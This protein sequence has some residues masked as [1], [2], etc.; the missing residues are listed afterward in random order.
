MLDEGAEAIVDAAMTT[1]H[2]AA[3]ALGARI[4][5]DDLV[6]KWMH[7]R[8][9]TSGLQALTR[10]GYVV[11]TM[12]V[13]ANWAGL[14]AVVEQV[15]SAMLSVPHARTAT[16]HLSHSYI[17]GACVYFTFA[18]N[19]PAEE[20]EATYLAMWERGQNAA[21][22]AGASLSHHHGVGLSRAGFMRA[23]LGNGLD[24]L[25]AVKSALDPKG[26]LNPGKLGL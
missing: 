26:I 12:E 9:D 18:A 2:D 15:E 10:K 19:P 7:H 6:E 5:D 11:D 1:V 4:L 24:V 17:E 13:A 25:R 22:A 21:I 3:L 14:D 20:F 16:C 8:N 23:A